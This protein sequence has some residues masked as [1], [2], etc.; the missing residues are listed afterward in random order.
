[1][2]LVDG[3]GRVRAM[4]E[5][6]GAEPATLGAVDAVVANAESTRGGSTTTAPSL[7]QITRM[8][9]K[10]PLA[11]GNVRIYNDLTRLEEQLATRADAVAREREALT[12]SLGRSPPVKELAA[13]VGCSPERVLEA[14]EAA[15]GY[16]ATSLDAP[17]AGDEEGSPL[18]DLV[19][20]VDGSYS[21]VHTRLAL[22]EAWRELPELEREVLALRF[23]EDLTQREI[24]ERIGF[25]Q[26]HVSRVLRRALRRLSAAAAPV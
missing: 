20:E 3:L 17:A 15:T 1:M 26:M 19:G 25:S 22:A 12:K 7:L 4:L 8:L 23:V 14:A 10:T 13:A 11:S 5:A 9:L 24:G 21:A 6:N 16:E 18:V 2:N